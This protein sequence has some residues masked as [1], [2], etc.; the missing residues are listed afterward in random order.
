VGPQTQPGGIANALSTL[1][2]LVTQSSHPD[3]LRFAVT[4]YFNYAAAN[5]S[6]IHKP[7]LYF[8]DYGL[9]NRT[10]RGYVFD[11]A[12]LTLVEG[13]FTVA[14]GSGSSAQRD[15]RRNTRHVQ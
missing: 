10:R 5:P 2:P 6:S 11:M 15:G 1:G 7:Y 4:A 13:P 3:A 9:N 12:H 8:V 14:H